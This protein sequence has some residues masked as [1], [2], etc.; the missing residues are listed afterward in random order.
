MR[1][2]F[3]RYCIALLGFSASNCF[4]SSSEDVKLHANMTLFCTTGDII[5]KVV[6][7][8]HTS[9]SIKL[10][11]FSIGENGY[12]FSNLF[13]VKD[14]TKNK[15]LS[16]SGVVPELVLNESIYRLLDSKDSITNWYNLSKLYLLDTNSEY[17]VQYHSESFH[18]D[19]ELPLIIIDSSEKNISCRNTNPLFSN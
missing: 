2:Y 17:S 1:K 8:N 6:I 15:L 18:H 5:A 7:K 12:I 11:R 3:I 9:K 10:S 4:A 16:Y 14:L 13:N 19:G